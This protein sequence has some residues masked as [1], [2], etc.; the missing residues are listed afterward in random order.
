[1]NDVAVLGDGAWGTACASVLADNGYHVKLWCHNAEVAQHIAMHGCNTIYLP[2]VML[3]TERIQVTTDIMYAIADVEYVFEAIPV[4]H[5]RA[6]LRIMQREIA[7]KKVWICLS[8][9][10]EQHTLL[11]PIG[12]LED[13]FGALRGKAVISGPSFAR[14]LVRKQ[15]TAVMLATDDDGIARKIC[16]MFA[17]DYVHTYASQDIVGVQLC[18]ALKNGIALSVG[19]LDGLGYGDN[20]QIYCVLRIMRE[21]A[22]VLRVIGGQEETA[23]DLAGIG[24][25]MLTALGSHSKNVVAGK[26][27]AAGI[28]LRAITPRNEVCAGRN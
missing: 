18:G 15:L 10:I 9:G 13:M 21:I 19:M 4:A 6:S 16:H 27:I 1:M 5:M 24:D 12:I 28:S 3:D 25:I 22:T 26:R 7:Q 2:G 8:K 11:F 14:D 17:N 20:T 23:H